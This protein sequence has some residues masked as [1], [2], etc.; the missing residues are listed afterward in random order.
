MN[1]KQIIE[2]CVTRLGMTQEQ[3]EWVAKNLYTY[4]A[5]D[6]SEWSWEQID[7]CFRDVLWFKDKT[8][9]EIAAAL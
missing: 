1:S 3:A 2:R 7:E 6:F 9:A 8:D 4:A 5:P